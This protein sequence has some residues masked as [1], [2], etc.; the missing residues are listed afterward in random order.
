ME[1]VHNAVVFVKNVQAP[2][3][4]GALY[5]SFSYSPRTNASFD[6]DVVILNDLGAEKNRDALRHFPGREGYLYAV[7]ANWKAQLTPFE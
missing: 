1:G 2:F 7:D 5:N 6:D 4:A 3:V